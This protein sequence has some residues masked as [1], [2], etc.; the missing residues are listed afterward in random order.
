M[1]MY[2]NEIETKEKKNYLGLKINYNR[3][4]KVWHNSNFYLNIIKYN[5]AYTVWKRCNMIHTLH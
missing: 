5:L 3:I 4:K 2:A 1:V